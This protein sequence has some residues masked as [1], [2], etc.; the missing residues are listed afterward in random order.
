MKKIIS[1]GIFAVV[2]F[3]ITFGVM[4]SGDIMDYFN[5]GEYYSYVMSDQTTLIVIANEKSKNENLMKSIATLGK[6]YEGKLA[7]TTL[8]EKAD[9]TKTLAFD[10]NIEE[11]HESSSILINHKG[12]VISVYKN[13]FPY[14]NIK[15]DLDRIFGK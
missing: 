7:I 2:V 15:L 6:D 1:L 9:L 14:E 8:D 13:T 4:K 10:L 11:L 5:R 3:L 12:D